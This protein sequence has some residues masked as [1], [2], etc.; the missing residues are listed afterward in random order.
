MDIYIV[1]QDAR[2]GHGEPRIAISLHIL[3]TPPCF[4]HRFSFSVTFRFCSVFVTVRVCCVSNT[5][6]TSPMHTAL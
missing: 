6:V 3:F 2:E 4:D 5:T 1:I